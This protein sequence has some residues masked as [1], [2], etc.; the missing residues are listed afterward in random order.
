MR[1][2]RCPRLP[3]SS[4]TGYSILL[5][6]ALTAV[7]APRSG[8]SRR[9]RQARPGERPTR[10]VACQAGPAGRCGSGLGP[11]AL[12]VSAARSDSRRPRQARRPGWRPTRLPSARQLASGLGPS[13]LAARPVPTRTASVGPA[14]RWGLEEERAVGRDTARLDT[15]RLP[16]WLRVWGRLP[17]PLARTQPEVRAGAPWHR[18]C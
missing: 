15:A 14:A 10:L 9:S 7:T 1:R 4:A 8:R 11:S 17:V 2:A 12:G 16:G 5:A 6:R 18:S 3:S 13:A